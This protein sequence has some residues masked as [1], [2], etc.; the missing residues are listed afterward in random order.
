VSVGFGIYTSYTYLVLVH[1]RLS[2]FG[3]VI[4]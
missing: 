3:A 2:R 1:G 4:V